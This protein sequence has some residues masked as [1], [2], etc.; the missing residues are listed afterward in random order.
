MDKRELRRAVALVADP[1]NHPVLIFCASGRKQ[2]SLVIGKS[3]S[4]LVTL[5]L[6][7]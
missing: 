3:T 1:A 7:G 4:G 6:Y 5:L 2:T